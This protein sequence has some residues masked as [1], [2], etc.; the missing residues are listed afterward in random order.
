LLLFRRRQKKKNPRAA[1]A[2]APID[3]PTPTPARAPVE[4]PDEPVDAVACGVDVFV[5]EFGVEVG[6]AELELKVEDKELAMLELVV[7]SAVTMACASTV[8]SI[9]ADGALYRFEEVEQQ[10]IPLGLSATKL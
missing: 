5:A 3:T 1:A 2:I 10:A 9:V 8:A 4:S 7:L 6:D